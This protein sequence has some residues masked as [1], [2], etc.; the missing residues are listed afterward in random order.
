M[1]IDRHLLLE[2]LRELS[3][4]ELQEASWLGGDPENTFSFTEAICGVFDDSGLMRELESGRL[5]AVVSEELLQKLAQLYDA[6]DLIPEESSPAT[7]LEHP[8][9]ESVRTLAG[10]LLRL[11]ERDWKGKWL[12][13][14]PEDPS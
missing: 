12:P 2:C 7:I 3:S 8:G 6:I 13:D 1:K 10:E 4:R 9:M 11:F 5:Q 14:I